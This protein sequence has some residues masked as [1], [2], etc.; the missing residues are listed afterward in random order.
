MPCCHAVC[1]SGT[2]GIRA[3]CGVTWY[4][5]VVPEPPIR[6]VAVTPAAPS[7]AER[8]DSRWASRMAAHSCRLILSPKRC[9][10]LLDL[11]MRHRRL[12]EPMAPES[13]QILP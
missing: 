6:L 7:R 11:L 5:A 9:G 10:N 4:A 3:A 13:V 2:R 8:R 1:Q 12:V